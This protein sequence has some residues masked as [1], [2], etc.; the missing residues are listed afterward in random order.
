MRSDQSMWRHSAAAD[1][2]SAHC[3]V[4]YPPAAVSNRRAGYQPAPQGASPSLPWLEAYGTEEARDL[5]GGGGAGGSGAGGHHDCVCTPEPLVFEKVRQRIVATVETPPVAA[6]SRDVPLRL[7]T[8]A[9][10]VAELRV[11]WKEPADKPPLFRAGSIVVGLKLV[12]I[13]K[14]DVDIQ[15]LT[16]SDPQV[17]LIIARDGSTNIPEPKVRRSGKGSTVEDILK[18]AVGHFSL[19]R[20]IFEVE[21]RSRVPFAARGANLNVNLAYDLLG[22]RYRGTV[23]ILPLRLTYDDYGPVPFAVNLSVTMEKNRLAIDSGT[24]ATGATQVTVNGALDDLAAPNAHFQ[25]QAGV[26]VTDVARI[27]RVP[28][29]RSGGALASGTGEWSSA[30]GLV[31]KGNV[32]ASGVEYRDNVLR[33]VNF[34]GDGA[35][36][37]SA[38]GV[39]ATGLRISGFYARDGRR[40]AVQ[41][42]IASFTLRDRNIEIGGV[43]LTL[44]NGSFRG[45]AGLRQLDRYS[46]TGEVSG[47]DTRR[48]IALYSS[49]PLPWDALVFGG[50][51]LEGSLKRGKELRAIGNLT[52]APAP[53]GD[54][55]RGQI[56]V[57]YD[58]G[59]G[60]LDLGRS[61][62]SLPHS[63]VDFS[64]ALNRELRV[65]LETHDLGDLLPALGKTAADV[66]VKLG[67]GTPPGAVLFD[68]NVVGDLNNPRIAGRLHASNF[69]FSDQHFDSVEGD[70]VA[71]ADYLRVQNANAAQGPLRAEFQGSVGLSNWKSSDTSPIAATGTLKNAAVTDLAALMHA[72]DLPLTGTFNGSAQVNGTIAAP[73]VQG[74][75]EL[76]KGSLRD[77]P[78]DRIAAHASYAA[79]TLTVTNGQLTAGKKQILLS[80]TFQHQADHFDTGRLNFDVSS[81]VVPLEEIRDIAS[82]Y[83]GMKAPSRLTARGQIEPQPAARPGTES[84]S[85]MI[86]APRACN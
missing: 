66:P 83:P 48:A 2:Q 14:R 52:L 85:Y 30:S 3:R 81:N 58:A 7:E 59:S 29:L 39:G 45:Q 70:V 24:I 67:T 60:V 38:A 4:C 31:L 46:V 19:E 44:L 53:S 57:A 28:Q 72:K 69:I 47:I 71:S 35:V 20:G 21:A 65:H 62:V 13:L 63:R 78:F 61:T 73:R 50:V 34:R 43:A 27:F 76:L 17:Y 49:E 26:A 10:R 68:G 55:V 77:E 86:S 23:A 18:L 84:T 1:C 36:S 42:K 33:L 5:A 32:N 22:P 37:A 74:D 75:V 6:W 51:K 82:R 41:G 40:E 15:S 8:S 54:E 9:G 12:S 56:Q 80:G 25:Y 79:N 16:V 11:A 64:G